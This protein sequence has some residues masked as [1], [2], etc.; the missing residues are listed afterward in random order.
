[1]KIWNKQISIRIFSALA[2]FIFFA[3]YVGVFS[4]GMNM[5][6]AGHVHCPF[7]IGTSICNMTVADHYS[8]ATTVFTALPEINSFI[9]L[10]LITFLFFSL[11]FFI[12][13]LFAP[14]PLKLKPF[15]ISIYS[16]LHNILQEAF[17][18]GILNSK[19][20]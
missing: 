18:N 17:S 7:M 8:V 13:K 16:P 2:L 9:F 3:T 10:S 14:P 20:F 6:S 15:S 11:L 19:A 1:M 5:D 4:V 12:P